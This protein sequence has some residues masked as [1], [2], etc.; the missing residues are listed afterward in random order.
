MMRIIRGLGDELLPRRK[1]AHLV[2]VYQHNLSF[3]RWMSITASAYQLSLLNRPER[4]MRG[5]R[6]AMELSDDHISTD[7]AL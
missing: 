3:T 1:R 6:G 5:K 7:T 4:G 2:E